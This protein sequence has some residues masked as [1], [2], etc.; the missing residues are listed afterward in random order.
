MLLRD[1]LDHLVTGATRT[2]LERYQHALRLLQCYIGDPVAVVDAAIDESPT[3]VMAHA[4]KAWLHLLGTESNGLPVAR[5]SLRTALQLRANRRETGHLEA[6]SRLIEGRWHDA[7]RVLEDVAIEYPND[8]LALQAGHQIDFFTGNSRMLRDRIARA[9]PAWSERMPGFHALL[10]MHA[11][12]LEES[13]DYGRAESQ[14]RRA[15]EL[16]PHDGWAQHAVAHVMEMQGRPS[17]GIAWMRANSDAWSRDSF[18]CVHNWWHL[19]LFHLELGQLDEVLALFDGPIDGK[20]ST[21]V[22]D[23]VD[24]SAL[25]WR[26]HLRGF[27][28]SGRWGVLADRWEPLAAAGNYAFND[29]HAM[30]AFVGADRRHAAA[31]ILE[32]QL[33]AM[34]RDDD[35]AMFTR[36]VGRPLTLAIKAF[37]EGA[38]AEAVRLLRPIRNIAARFG[39]SHAQRDLLDLTLIEA[40]FRSNQSRLASALVAERIDAK[41]SS[42]SVRALR[43]RSLGKAA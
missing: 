36:D 29:A 39:G 11:F 13:A 34:E 4:L 40:A 33:A 20:R 37:G 25:L 15:L 28:V 35:N 24:A 19:A 1:D 10:G 7:G 18:F 2:S 6:I 9:L 26:L 3:M 21:V 12:G 42:P 23:M 8:A 5:E 14:G 22:L 32:T 17:D 38:Y 41:P 30:M 27:D 16:E 31:S 43:D